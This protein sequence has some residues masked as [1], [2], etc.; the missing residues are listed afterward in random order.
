MKVDLCRTIDRNREVLAG[1]G[2]RLYAAA[3][4]W[5][6][7]RRSRLEIE[8]GRMHALSP[9]AILERG[10]A[11]CRNEQGAIMRSAAA[12]EPGSRVDVKLAQGELSCRVER[13]LQS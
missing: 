5:L 3:K 9:L 1:K 12:A 11:I 10:Y 4:A 2:T 6:Q 7:G 8:A 13:V